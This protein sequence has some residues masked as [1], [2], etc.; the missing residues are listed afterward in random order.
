MRYQT[1]TKVVV[2]LALLLTMPYVVLSSPAYL[3]AQ[4]NPQFTDSGQSL[5][6][7]YTRSVV[8]GDVDGDGD[9]D[10]VAGNSHGL[11]N[12]VYLNDGTG[13]FTDSGQNLGASGTY[14][15]GLGDVDSDGDLDLV[16]AN[17]AYSNRIWMNDGSG[18]FV[19]SN[20]LLGGY[21]Y[22][23]FSLALGDIDNDGDLDF[24]AG[25][26]K[27]TGYENKVY[28]N[29]GAGIFTDSG[30]SLGSSATRS[31]ALGD[32]D[33]DGDLDLAVGND[34]LQVNKV[35]LNNGTGTFTDSGQNLGSSST[36]AIL[37]GDVDSDGDLDLI[38]G[39]YSPNANTVWLNDGAGIFTDSG[40]N[41][42]LPETILSLSLGDVDN[43]GD[44][45]LV[46]GSRHPSGGGYP[47]KVYLNDGTGVFTDSG[48]NL[49]SSMTE[50]IALGDLDGD[51]DLDLVTGN[52]EY[53]LDANKVYINQYVLVIEA[54]VDFHPETLNLKG[55]GRVVTVYIELPEGY[56]ANDIDIGTVLLNGAVEAESKPVTIGDHN[57][58]SINDLM[59]KFDRAAV[60]EILTAGNQVEI[61]ITGEVAGIAF[62]G[63]DTIRVISQGK[64]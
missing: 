26:Y 53:G 14:G 57:G 60:Q 40:Q 47:N 61:T 63:S 52:A 17:Y 7:Y 34:L 37:F 31:V 12:K 55:K 25:N 9:L 48:Q 43:D 18:T 36:N 30:Q 59:V 11:P 49:G 19:D 38:V 15:I 44:L 29:D 58:N 28:I 51:G 46:Q 3:A 45:D 13:I 21:S 62:K 56:D 5:G 64:K 24:I 22:F 1:V 33:G 42:G 39:N 32:I 8:L 20:Q 27:G 35:Y 16:E 41:F 23:T 10:F 54:T 2:G 50:G 4:C 6:H